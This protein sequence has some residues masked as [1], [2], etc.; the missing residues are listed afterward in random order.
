MAIL[1][2][3]F[4]CLYFNPQVFSLLLFLFSPPSC[5][6]HAWLPAGATTAQDVITNI[7]SEQATH[8]H[9]RPVKNIGSRENGLQK[10]YSFIITLPPKTSGLNL[11]A[12][13][14]TFITVTT[15]HYFYLMPTP[16]LS[17]TL[18]T[19]IG[20]GF[21]CNVI[22]TNEEAGKKPNWF[23]ISTVCDA[24]GDKINRDERLMLL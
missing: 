16:L 13:L 12:L 8:S 18:R 23:Y 17:A 10:A 6:M 19:R 22:F 2:M 15:N 20:L 5:W 7:G 3:W 24:T 4:P 1:A 11:L 14:V 21:F 9:L